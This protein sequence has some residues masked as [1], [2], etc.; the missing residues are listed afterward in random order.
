MKLWIARFMLDTG[1][2][3]RQYELIISAVDSS[4]AR[5]QVY[6]WSDSNC[7]GDECIDYRTL[8]IDEIDI[9]TSKVLK[10]FDRGV[11]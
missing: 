6:D 10:V 3:Y 2:Y 1:A 5:R 8:I 9:S 11:V 4:E 7:R